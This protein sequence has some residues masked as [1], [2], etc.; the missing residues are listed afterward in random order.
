MHGAF[1]DVVVF[2]KD[3]RICEISKLRMRQSMEIARKLGVKG[4]V[5][6]T[7]CNPMLS[8]E[9]YD[10]N[11]ITKTAVYVEELLQAYSEIDIYLENMFDASPRMLVCISEQ[12]KKYSN[13][14][15]CLDYAHASISNVPMSEWVEE[16]APYLRHVHINDNDL[17][18]DLHLAV[19]MGQIDWNQFAKY[20]HTYFDQCSVLVETT[21]PGA[22]V[23]SLRYLKENFVGLFKS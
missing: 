20:Y 8:G 6:H 5:F 13:Y 12:L 18:R 21:L 3:E 17:K 15:V 11:V 9:S 10:Y 14:G 4:V 22:Q 1:L 23:Q 19:G 16:L 7:N 2:S